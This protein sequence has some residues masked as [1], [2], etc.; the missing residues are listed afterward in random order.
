ME[1]PYSSKPPELVFAK[2]QFPQPG[3]ETDWQS[4]TSEAVTA[5]VSHFLGC[6]IDGPNPGETPD[7]M[8]NRC[9]N[10]AELVSLFAQVRCWIGKKADG[11]VFQ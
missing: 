1:R 9:K 3:G 6:T 8:I 11:G 5:G 2:P 4:C 10:E 7:A